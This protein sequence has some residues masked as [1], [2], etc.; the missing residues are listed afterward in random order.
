MSFLCLL[1]NNLFSLNDRSFRKSAITQQRCVETIDRCRKSSTNVEKKQDSKC[2]S[3]IIS[4]SHGSEISSIHYI[5]S[6]GIS[7]IRWLLLEVR[8]AKMMIIIFGAFLLFWSPFFGT[9][10]FAGLLGVTPIIDKR[11]KMLVVWFTY[12]SSGVNPIIYTL[13]SPKFR[14]AF[15]KMLHIR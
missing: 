11:L 14:I 1:H 6:D 9:F 12:L 7:H 13:F 3:S 8:Q 4:T 5:Q 2:V 10:L 15:K